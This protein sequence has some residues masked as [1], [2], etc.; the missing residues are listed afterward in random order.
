MQWSHFLVSLA[1][2]LQSFCLSNQSILPAFLAK[3]ADC[4]HKCYNITISVRRW[5]LHALVAWQFSMLRGDS[6]LLHSFSSCTCFEWEPLEIIGTS[7]VYR[8]DALRV[9]QEC[10]SAER[11]SRCWPRPETI[12]NWSYHFLIHQWTSGE[13]TSCSLHTYCLAYCL[14]VWHSSKLSYI[15]TAV[16]YAVL[17][18]GAEISNRGKMS[19]VHL[20]KTVGRI[21][22][23]IQ[24]HHYIHL[25]S[26]V[27][28][29][30]LWPPYVIGG[31]HYIFAL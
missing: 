17:E 12:T 28:K 25:G 29:F 6:W 30:W 23:P 8:L 10:R 18:A 20:S 26:L 15:C 14:D 9:N 11:N 27:S 7:F 24:L 2:F 21:W 1:S 16:I 19:H 3:V 31:G 4:S 22:M 5:S 13:E